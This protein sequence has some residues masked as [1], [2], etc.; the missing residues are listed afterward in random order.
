MIENAITTHAT[1]GKLVSEFHHCELHLLVLIGWERGFRRSFSPVGINVLWSPCSNEKIP[2]F[3]AAPVKSLSQMRKG[4]LGVVANINCTISR[5]V[6][7]WN[8]Y[9]TMKA[10]EQ[11][12]KFDVFTMLTMLGPHR[13]SLL[14][15]LLWK[16]QHCF[17]VWRNLFKDTLLR[18]RKIICGKSQEP[19]RIQTLDHKLSSLLLWLNSCP[20]T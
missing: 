14:S 3:A 13:F 10:L 16:S 8:R 1:V 17:I 5:D 9:N 18:E 15:I 12:C 20:E 2:M 4:E 19:A 6:V 11:N 7:T